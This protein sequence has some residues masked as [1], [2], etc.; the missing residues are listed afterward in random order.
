MGTEQWDA[1]RPSG[2]A[3]GASGTAPEGHQARLLAPAPSLYLLPQ[4]P[5]W[6]TWLVRWGLRVKVNTPSHSLFCAKVTGS[7]EESLPWG[8]RDAQASRTFPHLDL[9]LN[10]G[11]TSAD[12]EPIYSSAERPGRSQRD[13]QQTFL[14]C[15]V[16]V[17]KDSLALDVWRRAAVRPQ[18]SKLGRCRLSPTAF[19]TR[20]NP[21]LPTGI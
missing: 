12:Q 5:A 14:K 21:A 16:W 7:S 19:K 11:P 10:R 4:P 2:S 6:K 18:V 15:C 9:L 1:G 17:A 13:L 8:E 3:V 20:H